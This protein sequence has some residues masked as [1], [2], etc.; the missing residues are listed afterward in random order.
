MRSSKRFRNWRI[1]SAND[2]GFRLSF[3]HN[4]NS[5]SDLNSSAPLII[6]EN[7]PIGTVVGEF[8][9]TDSNNSTVIFSLVQGG[10]TSLNQYFAL[11]SG[12]VLRTTAVLDY[13][14]T[15][16]L[17]IR[18][19][20]SG[21]NGD[22]FERDF[23]VQI[24]DLVENMW[25]VPHAG[26]WL[27][28]NIDKNSSNWIYNDNLGWA[29]KGVADMNS[30]WMNLPDLGCV[31]TSSAVYPRFFYKN[32]SDWIH[33]VTPHPYNLFDPDFNASRIEM[34]PPRF[35]YAN[36]STWLDFKGAVGIF[37]NFNV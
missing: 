8:N 3:Q 7:K 9:A 24:Q 28:I 25:T 6:T 4:N 10:G 17:T 11:D 20:A 31:W 15:S 36:G 19:R 30:T 29:Y 14:Q 2:L 23:Q 35:Y 18:V 34:H 13:E 12:G 1:H 37:E 22:S 5:L 33:L 26:D 21:S 16:N 27:G 32:L